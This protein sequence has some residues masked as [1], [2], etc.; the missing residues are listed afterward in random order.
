MHQ[1]IKKY[2]AFL[3]L[4][5]LVLTT[6]FPMKS[7][8]S[9]DRKGS[10][11]ITELATSTHKPVPGVR[12]TLYQ[13]ATGIRAENS[14]VLTGD[15]A[16]SGLELSADALM[17]SDIASGLEKYVQ[18]HKL[19]GLI[20][21]TTDANGVANFTDLA[22]GIYLIVQS[23]REEDFDKLGY[24]A[25]A[26]PYF[27]EIP[28]ADSE[29]GGAYLYNVS[30]KPKCDVT[31]HTDE[32]VAVSVY[33]EWKD[34]S[35]KA[36]KRPKS[37]QVALY[38]GESKE[39]TQILSAENNW[40][41]TWSGLDAS[42]DWKVKEVKVPAGYNS[43]VT[44]EGWSFTIVN[45]YNPPNTPPD[46]PNNPPSKKTPKTGDDAM[47]MRYMALLFSAV[48]ALGVL[49]RGRRNKVS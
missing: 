42:G 30:C 8:A 33:K 49:L 29:N 22:C 7:L 14:A 47:T 13:V 6:A 4:A 48:I 10:I 40:S 45:T 1:K 36:G 27:V 32:P 16:D 21:K 26:S 2:A 5:I 15:F 44:K 12:L 46:T 43:K 3:L 11:L 41:H 20:E 38:N 35:D 28:M 25:K 9:E 19:T 24:T 17:D 34:N 23:N 39:D 18:E 31:P 37:I